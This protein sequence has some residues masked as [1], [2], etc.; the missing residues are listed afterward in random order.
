M[1]RYA[2]VLLFIIITIASFSF[3]YDN[4]KFAFACSCGQ[5]PI[6]ERFEYSQLCFRAE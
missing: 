6:E 2:R 1:H 4:A 5:I 3:T